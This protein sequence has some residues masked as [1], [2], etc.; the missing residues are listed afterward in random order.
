MRAPVRTATVISTVI[1]SATVV[2]ISTKHAPSKTSLV[3]YCQ[4]YI[5]RKESVLE[6]LNHPLI[7]PTSLQPKAYNTT[8]ATVSIV[9]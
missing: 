4:E 9:S 3:R 7:H 2:L 8:V 6:T 1:C 5:M